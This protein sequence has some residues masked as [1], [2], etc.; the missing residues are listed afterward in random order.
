MDLDRFQVVKVNVSELALDNLDPE[1]ICLIKPSAL[2]DVVQ[3]L[4]V[5]CAL[6]RRFPDARIAWVVASAYAGLLERHEALDELIQFDRS[7][8]SV[9]TA[10][11]RAELQRLVAAVR[12]GQFDLAIDLQGLL[13]SGLICWSTAAERRV[14]MSDA[15]E[16]A[17]LFYTDT[18]QIP[19][20]CTLAIERYMRVA[21]ALGADSSEIG[22]RVPITPEARC[23]AVS[24]L[25][26]RAR[27]LLGLAP[28]ARWPTKRW[29]AER[30]AFLANGLVRRLGATIVLVGSSADRD[31]AAVIAA[32]LPDHEC[33]DLVGK[34]DLQQLA[35]VLAELRLLVTNDSG[36]M[37]LAA[38]LN[39]P[40]AAIF[41]CTSPARAAPHGSHLVI[42]PDVWCAG[43]YLKRCNRM[44][45][46]RSLN[47]EHVLQRVCKYAEQ[48]LDMHSRT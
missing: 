29:P 41:T 26:R 32:A 25:E 31:A 34:T 47:A 15:R 28:G 9:C 5:L 8:I 37:H 12:T 17:K 21:S 2:G 22:F 43:S 18:V 24:M 38:A 39:T 45:C 6:R 40:T 35:A 46:L 20:D 4:P 23:W 13:R 48:L 44:E 1:R 33:I 27:M 11:G 16:G 14:G 19:P 30:F 7:A 10:A 36:P 3:S 42:E